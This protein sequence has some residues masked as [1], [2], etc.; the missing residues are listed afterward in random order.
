[1]EV[2]FEQRQKGR[3]EEA[4]MDIK[5]SQVAADKLWHYHNQVASPLFTNPNPSHPHL[6]IGKDIRLEVVVVLVARPMECKYSLSPSLR[7]SWT[8]AKKTTKKKWMLKK[9]SLIIVATTASPPPPVN[10]LSKY[11]PLA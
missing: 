1:M 3:G 10:A 2:Y 4:Q 5:K 11:V 8:A 9:L 7:I 6:S